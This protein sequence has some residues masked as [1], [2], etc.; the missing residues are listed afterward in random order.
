MKKDFVQHCIFQHDPTTR[1]GFDWLNLQ[2]VENS[3]GRLESCPTIW[4]GDSKASRRFLT[5]GRLNRL[6]LHI[7]KNRHPRGCLFSFYIQNVFTLKPQ[8]NCVLISPTWLDYVQHLEQCIPPAL[9]LNMPG[10]QCF[11]SAIYRFPSREIHPP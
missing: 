11:G 10:R 7:Y 1:F 4:K 6:F 3:R 5:S 8:V 2:W 9:P